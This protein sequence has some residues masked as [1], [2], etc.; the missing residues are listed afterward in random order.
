MTAK[1]AFNDYVQRGLATV[2]LAHYWHLQTPSYAQHIALGEFYETLPELIDSVAEVGMAT[3][4]LVE[5]GGVQFMFTN[6][7]DAGISELRDRSIDFR[8][9][10]SGSREYTAITIALDEIITFCDKTLYKLRHLH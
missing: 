10:L 2:A 7:W 9:A 5:N 3:F 1:D 6:D 4:G 8:E